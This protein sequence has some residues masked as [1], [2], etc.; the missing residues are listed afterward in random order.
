MDGQNDPNRTHGRN[1]GKEIAARL[2][3]SL[4]PVA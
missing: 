3:P 1:Q 4:F 2:K